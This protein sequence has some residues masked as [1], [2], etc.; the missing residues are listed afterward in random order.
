[1]TRDTLVFVR[2]FLTAART[3][4]AIAPSGNALS[5]A[6]THHVRPGGPDQPRT[7]LEV[8]PGTGAVTRHLVRRLGPRD[9]LDLVESSPGFV[10]R[11]G[12]ALRTDPA[13]APVADRTRLWHG[14]IEEREL[15][16]YDTIVCGLPFANF[17]PEAVTAVFSRMLAALRPGGTLSFF[18]YA[19]GRALKGADPRRTAARR[20]VRAAIEPWLLEERLILSNLPPARVHHLGAPATVGALEAT[21]PL[22]P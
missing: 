11:L 13:L 14:K 16:E 4:G 10:T 1:M 19:G 3:T 22:T 21:V 9:A 12:R 8:G 7:V 17:P 2:A 20:A 15:G 5:R 18:S 6:L